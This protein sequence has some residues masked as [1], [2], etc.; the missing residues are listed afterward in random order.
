M[1]A[2]IIP[3]AS[4]L[5]AKDTLLDQDPDI[6]VQPL[7]DSVIPHKTVK[8]A[9]NLEDLEGEQVKESG[10]EN[11]EETSVPSKKEE[12]ADTVVFNKL[13]ETMKASGNLPEKPAPPV[14]SRLI[15]ICLCI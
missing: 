10:I 1:F 13:V 4:E 2:P 15:N 11:V 3:A 7:L 12:E 14:S 5:Y 6:D 8:G 9:V